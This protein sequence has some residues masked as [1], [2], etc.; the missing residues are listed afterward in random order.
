MNVAGAQK[1]L[2]ETEQNQQYK[3]CE[4]SNTIPGGYIGI[5][6]QGQVEQ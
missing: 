2:S 5:E 3:K 4:S 6:L 1:E